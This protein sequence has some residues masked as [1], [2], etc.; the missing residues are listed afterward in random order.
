MRGGERVRTVHLMA[1]DNKPLADITIGPLD[2][3]TLRGARLLTRAKMLA[4]VLVALAAALGAVFLA[5][6]APTSASRPT[7]LVVMAILVA[8]AG[9]G[10]G[11]AMAYRPELAALN[12]I[13]KEKVTLT[14]LGA[15]VLSLNFQG[16]QGPLG[17]A[18]IQLAFAGNRAR[19]MELQLPAVRPEAARF[20]AAQV[21]ALRATR[22]GNPAG[23]YVL[24]TMGRDGKRRGTVVALGR[25]IKLARP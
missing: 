24:N 13:E 5:V 21:C 19:A 16:G 7:D 20:V 18:T 3:E 11:G 8:L 22:A 23:P 14:P 9:A 10:L 4:L 25:Q 12:H 2:A 1:D 6:R 15:Q 17:R